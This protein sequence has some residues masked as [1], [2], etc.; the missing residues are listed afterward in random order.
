LAAERVERRL[1]AVL[2]A[3]VAG[4]SRLMGTDEEGT[5]ARLKA[6]RKTFVDPTIASNRG[7]VVKT[8]GDGMLV[9]FASAVDAVRC[10][11]EVQSGMVEQ[12]APA[13]QEM[14]IEFRIGIHVG[15][16]IFDDS[17]IFGDGVNIAARLEGIA[18]PGGVCMSDDTHRQVRGKV[19]IA[20]EDLGPQTLKNIIEP[21]R[22]WRVQIDKNSPSLTP[23]RAAF[24]ATQALAA[25][26][27]PSIA[28]LPFQNMSGNPEQ[29]YFADGLAEDIITELSRFRE[30]AVIAR[31]S[32][33]FYKGKP[34]DVTQ[35]ARDLRV[36]YVLE[37]SVRQIG[38]RVRVTAQL[39]DAVTNDHLWAERY[40]REQADVF[41]LQEEVTRTVVASI[42][43]QIGL[44]EIAR[45]RRDTT[46]LHARQLAWRA[47]GLYLDAYNSGNAAMMQQTIAACEEAIAVDPA[48]LEAHAT[49]G[50]AHYLC[51]L[52]RWG[53]RPEGALDRAWA[54]VER[55][56]TINSQDERTLTLRG[57]IRFN[58]GEYDGG[59]SDLRR[60]CEVN[61][62]FAFALTRLSFAEAKAGMAEEAVAHAKLALRLSPKDYWAGTAH[63]AMTLAY[64]ALQNYTE[65]VRW[66]ESAIQVSH[67][68]PIR[69]ALMIACSARAGDMARAGAEI[70]V[71][72]SFAPGFIASVFRGENP[73]F[74]RKE[75]MEHLLDGLRLAGL[76]E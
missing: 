29:E 45:S 59:L 27:K 71:L 7:R 38:N 73:V 13:P 19:E 16:I 52:Y 20:C 34:I 43:P 9:E 8:T 3:D 72:D 58:R 37:G 23:K 63:L 47:R 35:V 30:F 32:T 65:A 28:V 49:L 57:W 55:M 12:N 22:A 21:M 61:P 67:R 54:V 51:H 26:D 42:A 74:T 10:A 5:L 11:V 69:R 33:F 60:A 31:N 41:D 62:N 75:D 48:S 70:A 18:E 68:A 15:D 40:D 4:Y 56:T 39:I 46:N 64:F 25:P 2:A 14:R 17:D 50:N 1:A 44:A 24:E 53:D 36:R 66:C 6:V 76:R